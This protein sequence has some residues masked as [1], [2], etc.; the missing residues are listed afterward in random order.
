LE[1]RRLDEF[2]GGEE[3]S[4][5][6]RMQD[7]LISLN[8]TLEK[9]VKHKSNVTIEI[10][11]SVEFKGKGGVQWLFFNIGGETARSTTMK[12]VIETTIEPKPKSDS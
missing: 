6:V 10:S 7:L 9:S 4:P 5:A 11:G 8:D 3:E 2:L 12:V 1:D